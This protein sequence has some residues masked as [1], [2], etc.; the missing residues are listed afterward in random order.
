MSDV[1][2]HTPGCGDRGVEVAN[3]GFDKFERDHLARRQFRVVADPL[4]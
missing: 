3:F 1:N 4:P 2:V